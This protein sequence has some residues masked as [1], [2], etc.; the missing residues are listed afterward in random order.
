MV[1]L[2]AHGRALCFLAEVLWERTGPG[3]VFPLG[4]WIWSEVALR[5]PVCDGHGE[6]HSCMGVTFFQPRVAPANKC[7]R[8]QTIMFL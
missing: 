8:M 7:P 1:T 2:Q 5:C 6:A 3:Q 4:T